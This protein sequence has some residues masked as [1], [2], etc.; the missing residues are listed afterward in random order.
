MNIANDYKILMFIKFGA[1][2]HMED[3]F[4][5]GT[6]YM[7]PIQYF[8]NFEDNELRGDSYE[9]INAIRNYPEGKFEIPS[10]NFKGHYLNIHLRQSYEAVFGNIFSLY[11]ISSK[12][13]GN[14]SEFRINKKN[15]KFGSHCV[16][17]KDNPRFLSLIERKLS[18]LKVHYRHNLVDYYD[19]FIGNRSLTLFNKPMEFAY[20]NEFRIY[21]DR[22]S[23][24]PLSFSI[25]SL[26]DFASI[27]SSDEVIKHLMLKEEN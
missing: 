17:I 8:K 21:A 1:Q 16:I 18:D 25:G 23:M 14:P 13:W 2:P 6:I 26:Y 9:G 4:H 20:Q 15:R 11:C 24:D 3:L 5:N 12:N 27:H 7:N 10:L 19:R 22:P